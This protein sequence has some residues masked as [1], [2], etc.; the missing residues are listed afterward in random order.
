MSATTVLHFMLNNIKH[1]INR[2]KTYK[3]K[4]SV[5]KYKI[6]SLFLNGF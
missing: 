5:S 3:N 4:K 2:L 1:S 6:H